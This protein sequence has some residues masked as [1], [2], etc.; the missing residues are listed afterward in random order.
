MMLV[1]TKVTDRRHL[2][3]IASGGIILY[4]TGYQKIIN[5]EKQY[6]T[7]FLKNVTWCNTPLFLVAP[8]LK[9]DERINE[10]EMKN[11]LGAHDG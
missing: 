9:I 10:A 4:Q 5:C 6:S 7:R 8:V 1:V 11:S 3:E 2:V